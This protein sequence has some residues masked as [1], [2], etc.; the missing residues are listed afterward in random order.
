MVK[1]LTVCIVVVEDEFMAVGVRDEFCALLDDRVR[2]KCGAQDP[3][4]FGENDARQKI[5]MPPLEV[6]DRA[7]LARLVMARDAAALDL[8][9][10]AIGSAGIDIGAGIAGG[11]PA[12]GRAEQILGEFA[13]RIVRRTGDAALTQFFSDPRL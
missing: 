13:G 7:E 2:N 5:E 3:V 12:K 8:V 10:G 6:A 4:T 9:A 11:C 1:T